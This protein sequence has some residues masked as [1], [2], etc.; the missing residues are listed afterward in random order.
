MFKK[1]DPVCGVRVSKNTEYFFS[2]Q[3]KTYYFDCQACKATFQENIG[4]Y[5][6]R[7]PTDGFLNWIAKGSGKVPKSCHEGKQKK[8]AD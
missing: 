5:L 2:H 1:R 7:K 3:G 8:E 4:D 6:R